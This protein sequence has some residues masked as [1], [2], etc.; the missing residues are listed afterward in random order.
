MR[1]ALIPASIKIAVRPA[2]SN[3]A[4]PWLPLASMLILKLLIAAS[5]PGRFS[6]VD[7]QDPPRK[8]LF[9]ILSDKHKKV[10]RYFITGDCPANR[11]IGAV[12][13]A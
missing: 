7:H 12:F 13:P 11:L 2:A 3:K 1:A 10:A 9:Y 8:R 5:E 4:L 6:A